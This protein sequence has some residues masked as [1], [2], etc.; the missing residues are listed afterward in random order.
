[1]KYYLHRTKNHYIILKIKTYGYSTKLQ[2]TL[3]L[4]LITV[5]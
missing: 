1:M 2:N 4:H 5:M 3:Q